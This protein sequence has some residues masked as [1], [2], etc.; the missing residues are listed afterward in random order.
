[1]FG[2]K[3]VNEVYTQ[4]NCELRS[5]SSVRI[6]DEIESL[7]AMLQL[8]QEGVALLEDVEEKNDKLINLINLGKFIVC[9]VQTGIHAKQWY[10][11]TSR[12]KIENSR[13]EIRRLITEAEQIARA[14]ILN[15]QNAIPIVEADSRLGWEPSMEYMC[16]AEH[17]RWKIR[18]V[19]YV[20][21]TELA[22]FKK[23]VEI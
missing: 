7:S 12:L 5:L 13:S 2:A 11:V 17:I 8:M 4:S 10:L 18:Q 3:I 21:E 22:L 15:A 6:Q 9:C 23:C 16:D 14:E 20:L 19:N 1:M